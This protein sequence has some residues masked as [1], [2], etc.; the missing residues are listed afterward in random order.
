MTRLDYGQFLLSS[1]INYTQTYFADHAQAWS[2]DTIN[3]YLRDEPCHP[4]HLVWD[5]VD[6]EVVR[7]TSAATCSSTTP[8]STSA[9]AATSS[10][11]VASGAETPKASSRASAS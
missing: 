11:P 7:C 3:R 5:N 6:S 2:H 1:Q 10:R 4:A 8:C 9:T